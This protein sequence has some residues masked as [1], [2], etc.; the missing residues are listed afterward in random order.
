MNLG[1]GGLDVKGDLI[2]FVDKGDGL[3]AGALRKTRAGGNWL[4]GGIVMWWWWVLSSVV[5][6]EALRVSQWT[7]KE[8]FEA[9]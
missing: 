2:E 7:V 1:V 8:D 9:L 6:V 3:E 5:R 4:T